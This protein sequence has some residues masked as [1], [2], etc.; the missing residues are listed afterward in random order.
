MNQLYSLSQPILLELERDCML[1]LLKMGKRLQELRQKKADNKEI[2]FL[3]V[4][5]CLDAGRK[6]WTKES[7]EHNFDW[8]IS[9]GWFSNLLIYLNSNKIKLDC[10]IDVSFFLDKE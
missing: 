4:H 3:P 9:K 1:L 5:H 2:E 6:Y 8:E 7:G 10:K